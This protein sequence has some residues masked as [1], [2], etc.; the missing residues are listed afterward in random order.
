MDNFA[1]K[2]YDPVGFCIYCKS[3]DGLEREHVLP[4][5]LGGIAVLPKASCRACAAITGEI[6]QVVMRG[7]MRAVRVYRALRS[8]TKHK[9]APRTY[10][11]TIIKNGVEEK[12]DLAAE[13]Y[14]ILLHF[15]VFS[16]P[17]SSTRRDT[18]TA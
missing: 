3:V 7:P 9:D 11:L 8:R 13:D 1:D 5:G 10:A 17:L 16:E 15:P 2:I 14:P 6:E 12:I 4:L 18:R